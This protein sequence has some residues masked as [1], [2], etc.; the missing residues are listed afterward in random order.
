M[1]FDRPYGLSSPRNP[2]GLG[3]GEFLSWEFPLSHWLEMHGYDVTYCSNVD[4]LE[5]EQLLRAKVFISVGHDEY[6]DLRQYDNAMAG[7]KSGVTE[8]YLR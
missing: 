3:A 6:W 1:S 7:V 5:P 2:Q 8:L 4:M